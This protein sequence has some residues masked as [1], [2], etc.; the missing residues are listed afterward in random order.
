MH[1]EHEYSQDRVK[2]NSWMQS[3]LTLGAKVREEERK[4]C[5]QVLVEGIMGQRACPGMQSSYTHFSEGQI[6]YT[7]L[8]GHLE[9]YNTLWEVN[10]WMAQWGKSI[11]RQLV[12]EVQ[13]LYC[14]V[15]PWYSGPSFI[16]E[17][18]INLLVRDW[19]AW[20]R[21][22]SLC[23]EAAWRW[24]WGRRPGVGP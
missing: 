11:I 15:N 23:R 9:E 1:D 14:T 8:K 13:K 2:G 24:V 6:T 10:T 12:Y 4:H 19:S 22:L 5:R 18:T 21:S 3:T 20:G 16:M 7:Q 17:G